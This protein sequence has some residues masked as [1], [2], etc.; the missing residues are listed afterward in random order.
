MLVVMP[1]GMRIESYDL[2]QNVDLWGMARPM[3]DRA[4]AGRRRV[5]LDAVRGVAVLSVVLYHCFSVGVVAPR[6]DDTVGLGWSG[7][8]AGRLGVDLFFVLSGYLMVG[9][10]WNTRGWRDYLGRRTRR[11]L[12][13]YWVSLVVLIPLVAPARLASASGWGDIALLAGLQGYVDPDLPGQVNIVYW[14]LTTEVHFYLLLPLLAAAMSRYGS[15]VLLPAA[16][17][18]SIGWRLFSPGLPESWI[19]GRIDQFV[20]GMAVASVIAAADAG[21]ISWVVRFVRQRWTGWLLGGALLATAGYHGTRFSGP[22]SLPGDQWAHPVAG[23]L[24]AGL[25]VRVL[26]PPA[27]GLTPAVG[28]GLSAAGLISFSLYLW[29]YPVLRYG[30]DWLGLTDPG[31]PGIAVAVGLGFLVAVSVAVSVVSYRLVEVP[32]LRRRTPSVPAGSDHA[33][34]APGGQLVGRVT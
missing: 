10:W 5:M 17:A 11:I 1:S 33:G 27:R 13:A 16:L 19:F 9:S 25:L 22:A 28:R 30:R 23:L 2:V 24:I 7:F 18:V 14:S 12:P 32:F 4:V 31:R 29:H 15:R 34:L 3:T 8:G 6:P 20:A 26:A 21:R